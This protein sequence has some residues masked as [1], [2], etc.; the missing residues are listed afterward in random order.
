MASPGAVEGLLNHCRLS[1]HRSLLLPPLRGLFLALL[2]GRALAGGDLVGGVPL[3][4]HPHV[5][6][7]RE[8]ARETCPAMFMITSSP[9]PIALAVHPIRRA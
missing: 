9:A 2:I 3:R 5:G 7:A 4:L 1:R 8:M 6:V